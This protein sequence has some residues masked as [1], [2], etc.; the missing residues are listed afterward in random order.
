MAE[1][2]R[3]QALEQQVRRLTEAVRK[4]CVC[5][6]FCTNGITGTQDRCKTCDG[7]GLVA[8]QADFGL[9]AALT[10]GTG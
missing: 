2:A 7:T 1:C 5:Q 4:H 6:D 3:C 8:C 9:L 10:E